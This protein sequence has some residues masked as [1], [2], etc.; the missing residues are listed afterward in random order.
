MALDLTAEAEKKGTT[1]SKVEAVKMEVDPNQLVSKVGTQ[2]PTDK[3]TPIV[4][5]E[6]TGLDTTLP[7][8]PENLGQ[9]GATATSAEKVTDAQKATGTVS[10]EIPDVVGTLSTGAIATPATQSLDEKATIKYQMADLMS[11][12]EEG[13]PLPPWASPAVRKMSAVMAARGMGASS[14]AAAA[15][16]QA[17]MEAGV[18]I[19]AA[20]AQSYGRIQLQNL[21]NEQQTALTNAATVA[22]MD[23]ANLNAR[24]TASVNNAKNFL[25]MD[26]QNLSSDQASKA[27]TYQSKTQAL[28]T[29]TAQENARRQINAKTETQVEEFFAELGTQ[30]DAANKNRTAAVNQFNTSEANAMN[31][32]NQTLIDSREKF[33][34]NMGFAVDQSNVQWRRQVNT[35]DTAV[36]NETNRV[37][38]QMTFN[39]SQQA[40]NYL[41]QKYRDNASFNF[42]K[43]ENAFSREHAIGLMALEYSYN[44]QLLDEQEKKDLLKSIGG[45]IRSWQETN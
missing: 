12:I 26:L 14:M 27:L 23:T 4:Q 32:Y 38:A 1:P 21:N 40:M 11:S 5:T 15:M 16:T 44:T 37:N 13:K 35:A 45:F 42:Q 36:Q 33:N 18:P 8:P 19:A 20:D 39:A 3:S 24:L 9:I 6:T 28:F 10:K 30:V 43:I 34:A 22:A 7:T 29:D 25:S 41:W 17:V 2:I 31:Q